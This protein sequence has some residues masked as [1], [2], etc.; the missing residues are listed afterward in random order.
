MKMMKK[1]NLNKKMGIYKKKINKLRKSNNHNHN[2][3][4]LIS[5]QY[6]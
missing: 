6:L 4:L 2:K 3:R 5:S 1:E